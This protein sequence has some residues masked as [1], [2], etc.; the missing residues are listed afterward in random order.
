VNI[1]A[2]S[3]GGLEARYVIHSLGMA[4]RVASLTTISTPHRGA[5]A[6]NVALRYP[7]W[8]YRF[9]AF[10]VNS[11]C[12]MTGDTN[13]D[14]YTGSRQLSEKWCRIFNRENPDSPAVYYQ[15]Y[16]SMLR[17]FF[18]DPA[19]LLTYV[20]VK[21]Y[22]GD[23]DGL[24]PVESARWTNFRGV[25]T[26]RGCFGISH[27]G[28]IDL[29]RVNYKGVDIPGFYLTIVRELAEKGF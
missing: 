7:G 17:Y 9:A 29:Y 28:I 11:C 14:F 26:T 1:L 23:N 19:Y 8:L 20:L 4:G 5:R 22:D 24:C 10:L 18:G 3:R 27:G 16:A 6:M 2:H 12:R 21:V 25:V 13:P 15:S